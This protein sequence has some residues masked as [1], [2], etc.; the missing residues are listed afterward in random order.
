[1]LHK[2]NWELERKRRKLVLEGQVERP[3]LAF[4]PG[5][6]DALAG[7]VAGMV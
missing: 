5:R 2:N 3:W 4:V 6:R 7:K 1:M